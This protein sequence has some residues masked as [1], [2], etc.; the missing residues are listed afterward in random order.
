[1]IDRSVTEIASTRPLLRR[2]I[3]LA[4]RNQR[5]EL[6][7]LLEDPLSGK[8]F[9]IGEKEHALISLLDGRRTVSDIIALSVSGPQ[10]SGLTENE[11]VSLIRMLSDARL[12]ESLSDGHSQRIREHSS[13]MRDGDRVTQKAKGLFFL[14]LPLGNPDR[15]LSAINRVL[16]SVPGWIFAAL[17]FAVITWALVIYGEN[18]IRFA[19]EMRGVLKVGNFA[20]F[21]AVW[22]VLKV[23]H[24]FCHGIVCKRFGGNVPEAG[25]SLLLFVT[26]LAYV[27]ASSSIRFPSKWHRIL[28]AAAGILGEFLIAALALV[29]WASV[30]PGVLGAVL[31]QVVVISTV[32]TL[33]FNANPLMR[34]D[35]YYIAADLLGISNLYTKGQKATNYLWKRWLLGIKGVSFPL[36]GIERRDQVIIF[37]YGIAS[38]AWRVVVM[39]GLFLG[40]CLLFQGAGKILAVMV[41]AAMVFGCIKGLIKY[42]KESAGLEK[43]KP[44]H[45]LLRAVAFAGL[46]VI[47]GRSI[48]IS[49]SVTAPAILDPGHAG[50]I[51]VECPGFVEELHVQ[52][53]AWVEEGD[54]IISL[55]NREVKTQ[56]NSMKLE[57]ARA[58]LRADI[59]L[60]DENIAGYQAEAKNVEGLESKVEDLERYVST[61]EM[62]APIAG[63]VY[64]RDLDSR[65]GDFLE[66]GAAAIRII[67]PEYR[68]L[69]IAVAQSR[70]DAIGTVHPGDTIAVFDRDTGVFHEATLERIRPQA[71]LEA[72]HPGLTVPGGGPL[73]VRDSYEGGD[74]V[75]VSPHFT[76]IARLND[77]QEL[78]EGEL[79]WA[80]FAS[81]R[82]VTLSDWTLQR[83]QRWISS[84]L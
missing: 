25:I 73:V 26:P 51:R 13:E 50:E 59:Y 15:A 19:E 1:M 65:E 74:P 8:F 44:F 78:R 5:G 24:E 39:I 38:A 80:K 43:A 33:L 62:R 81:T 32:T 36:Q 82:G 18:S 27:D 2:E 46:L 55:Q 76:A 54:K 84:S 35:G 70:M 47:A 58:K 75:L 12:L 57:L 71:G 9:E 83:V 6:I 64:A 3:K 42:F 29:A 72:P 37:A 4:C 30:S 41:A 53:G 68:E 14:K 77:E 79:L 67:N 61:L 66:K 49:P 40:A 31:H 56:L 22:L 11:A 16:G 60:Q 10:A 69:R 21:G 7:Y 48:Q 45:L 23:V 20:A 34:F 17:W 52:N 28:V 63:R